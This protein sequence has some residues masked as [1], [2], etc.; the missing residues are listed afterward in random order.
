MVGIRQKSADWIKLIHRL[1]GPHMGRLSRRS[2]LMSWKSQIKLTDTQLAILD[3][4]VENPALLIEGGPGTGKSFIAREAASR[5][6]RAGREV[7]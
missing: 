3:G 5:F 4:L 6:K 1:W 2:S 7:L